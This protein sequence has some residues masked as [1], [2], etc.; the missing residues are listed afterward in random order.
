[1]FEKTPSFVWS[2]NNVLSGQKDVPSYQNNIL[3]NC[4]RDVR[5]SEVTV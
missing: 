2:T 5:I 1:M 3:S 4:C